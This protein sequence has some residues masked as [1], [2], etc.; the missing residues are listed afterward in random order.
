MFGFSVPRIEFWVP[1]KCFAFPSVFWV[2]VSLCTRLKV[3]ESETHLHCQ[4]VKQVVS[5][6]LKPVYNI[7]HALPAQMF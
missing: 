7:I 4:V 2:P 6:Q 3:R 5:L 1:R